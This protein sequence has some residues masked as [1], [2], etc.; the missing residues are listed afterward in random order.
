MSRRY[1]HLRRVIDFTGL[2]LHSYH[3]NK[4]AKSHALQYVH[5]EMKKLAP[6]QCITVGFVKGEESQRWQLTQHTRSN[7]K[8]GL[9]VQYIV[10]YVLRYQNIVNARLGHAVRKFTPR[11]GDGTSYLLYWQDTLDNCSVH[12]SS[13]NKMLLTKEIV[14]DN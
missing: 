9:A 5:H 10:Q 7:M 1:G 8:L 4:D 6:Y 2:V 3:Q 14:G 13:S 12:E 11:K